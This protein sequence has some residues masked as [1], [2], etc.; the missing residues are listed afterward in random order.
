METLKLPNG[1]WTLE[2]CKESAAQYTTR[3]AWEKTAFS[4]ANTARKHGWVDECCAHMEALVKPPNYWTLERCK[5]SAAMYSAR[6]EWA[7]NEGS[8]SNA[9]RANGWMDECCAH[10]T[11]RQKP[12]GYWTL[13]R[14]KESAAKFVTRAEWAKEVGTAYSKAKKFGWVGE[15]CAHMP[16]P[17]RWDLESAKASALK[18]SSRSKWRKG[19]PGAWEWAQRNG[20]LDQCV[21]SPESQIKER[22]KQDA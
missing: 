11:R 10:M 9:A 16:K 6:S 2:R 20:V 17:H 8:A 19:A 14:C 5:E 18:F 12:T 13:E 4:A 21:H 22:S 1:Y 7:K 3:S 15:C